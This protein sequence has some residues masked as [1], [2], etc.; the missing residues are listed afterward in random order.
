[1][2]VRWCRQPIQVICSLLCSAGTRRRSWILWLNNPCCALIFVNTASTERMSDDSA[3]VGLL[4]LWFQPGVDSFS[5]LPKLLRVATAAWKPGVVKNISF[6]VLAAVETGREDYCPLAIVAHA[7]RG[8]ISSSFIARACGANCGA[9]NR[10]TR[11]LIS[12]AL[13]GISGVFTAHD[14][15]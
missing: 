15:A 4:H 5:G 12:T 6:V 10:P 13:C 7:Y 14:R 8:I 9:K 2:S 1:M 11:L 3:V